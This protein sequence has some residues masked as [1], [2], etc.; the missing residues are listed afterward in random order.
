MSLPPKS[1]FSSPRNVIRVVAVVLLAAGTYGQFMLHRVATPVAESTLYDVAMTFTTPAG[2]T[3]QRVQVRS[4]QT[5]DVSAA[6]QQGKLQATFAITAAGADAAKLE[7]GFGCNG[8]TTPTPPFT[9]RL[10]APAAIKA[11][12]EEGAPP[13]ALEMVVT[14]LAE[15][16]P[17][18]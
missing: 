16:A 1:F 15:V 9:A 3:A 14:K 5:I 10:G 8:A 17:V 18:K 13:C 4:G 2:S 7:G 12:A 11:K 6:D